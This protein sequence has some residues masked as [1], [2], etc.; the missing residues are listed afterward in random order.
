MNISSALFD[1][2]IVKVLANSYQRATGAMFRG[3]LKNKVLVFVYPASFRRIFITLFCPPLRILCFDNSG[4]LIFDQTTDQWGFVKLPKTRIVLEVDPDHN[5]NNVINAIAKDGIDGWISRYVSRSAVTKN[6][7]GTS[8]ADPYGDLVLTLIAEI[9][10]ELKAVREL[11]GEDITRKSFGALPSWQ[12]GQAANAA[13]WVLDLAPHLPYRLPASA[14]RMSEKLLAIVKQFGGDD[15]AELFAA[16]LAGLP[17]DLKAAC[18]RCGGASQWRQVLGP[19]M[20]IPW[21]SKWRLARPENYVPLCSR[22]QDNSGIFDEADVAIAMAYAYW[23]PRFAALNHWY[24]SVT[25]NTIPTDWDR[26]D[27]PLWPME[28]GGATWGE[29][30]G[31]IQHC[32]P[33][34]GK[35]AR[36]PEHLEI[37]REVLRHRGTRWTEFSKKG[38]LFS[39]LYIH[40]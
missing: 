12:Q 21:V 4:A 35:I 18:F 27:Y 26:E 34:L 17:W 25:T 36:K 6:S 9:M 24:Q 5:C 16:A 20:M 31:A 11:V 7:G 23:G 3:R 38:E 1:P 19:S 40:E 8:T 14:V 10:N 15:E 32:A 30:S 37:M 29:G 13:A 28:Y 33:R 2:V 39:L 22:C